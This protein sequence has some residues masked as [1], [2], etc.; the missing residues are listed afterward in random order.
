MVTVISIV[1][2]A[3][4]TFTKHLQRRVGELVIKGRIESIQVTG[5]F[6]QEYLEAS[7][8]IEDT[9]RCGFTG[10]KITVKTVLKNLQWMNV[11]IIPDII[12]TLETIPRDWKS[13]KL[14]DEVRPS[15]LQYFLGQP[16]YWGESS[17]FEE[18]FCCSGSREG[19]E[20]NTSE[21]NS[22]GVI[23]LAK[24]KGQTSREKLN[25]F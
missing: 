8:R 16:E 20:A 4:G 1:F 22:R 12:G 9:C 17:R 10:E 23:Y 15:K 11:T 21:K 18:I 7:W 5:M 24:K 25:L 2:G 13:W 3:L 6:Q 19:P 14:E